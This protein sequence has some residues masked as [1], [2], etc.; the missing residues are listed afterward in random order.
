[1]RD[2]L[3]LLGEGLRASALL[4]PSATAAPLA[5]AGFLFAAAL[6]LGAGLG[7]DFFAV[8]EP[9]EFNRWALSE[10]SLPVLLALLGGGL[11]AGLIGRPAVWLRLAAVALLAS[12]PARIAWALWPP[13]AS[14]DLSESPLRQVFIVYAA[15]VAMRLLRWAAGPHERLR[16]AFGAMLAAALV[17][18]SLHLVPGAVWWWPQWD[19]PDD[20]ALAVRDYSA[21][22]LL[23]AQPARVDA[24]VNALSPP[25]PD[26]I[27]L[28]AIAFG[29][30]GGESVFRNEVE[31]FER[32]MAQRFGEP[33]RTL[34][35]V[36]HPGTRE[37]RP[38]ATLSNLR[39]AVA[40][41]AARMDREE[42][43]LLLF[44]TSHGSAEHEL[45]V[46]LD[47]LPLDQ[48]EPADLGALLDAA[49]IRWRVLIVSACYSGGFIEPL[50]N[51]Q[52][53]ILTAA[54]ADRP[55]FGCGVASDVTWFGQ[56]LLAEALN[57]TVDLVDAFAVARKQIR[58]R[59]RDA[60]ERPS[61]PQ[62]AV[63]DGIRDH[64]QRWQRQLQPGPAVP[65]VPAVAAPKA[66]HRIEP[67][68][69][70]RTRSRAGFNR[71]HR[72]L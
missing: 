66:Q 32:L 13:S 62:I 47:D 23:Y 12:L 67:G 19:E 3:R 1:M 37:D 70:G 48:I 68:A 33:G 55:S 14:T 24:A 63:G 51:P 16:P 7:I 54:R 2:P 69:R 52:T 56:A 61:H 42:D 72:P 4:R 21:E 30:D 46:A 44:L 22:D 45:Y 65:Y 71:R 53:L 57:E 6:S 58:A 31:H 36:N 20:T 17:G 38:L 8:D 35:L 60:D 9:R 49:G 26:R 15:L 40:G 34:A 18:L 50:A 10:L 27:D 11:S 28:Y 59:E 43:I 64:L 25:R 5:P 41:I 39:R 29:G